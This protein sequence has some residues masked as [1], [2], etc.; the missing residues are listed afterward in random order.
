MD[1]MIKGNLKKGQCV[2]WDEGGVGLNVRDFMTTIN[3]CIS[4]YLQSFRKK[5][6]CVFF[7]VPDFFFLDSA[8]RKLLHGILETVTIR[9]KTQECVCKYLHIKYSSRFGKIYYQYPRIW[10]HDHRVRL[11]RI[12]IGIPTKEM[13]KKYEAKKDRFLSKLALDVRQK[14]RPKKRDKAKRMS[15]EECLGI[16]RKKLKGKKLT[17]SAI[18]VVTGV[19]ENRARK[20]RAMAKF[21]VR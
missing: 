13:R 10:R 19:S 2:L 9:Y 15:D 5:N 14:L 17:T 16:L 18:Q 12:N 4:Y 3:R 20:L 11:D 21:G 8:I 7:T 1:L 6:L